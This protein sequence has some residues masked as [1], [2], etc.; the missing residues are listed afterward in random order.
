MNHLRAPI[1]RITVIGNRA[2]VALGPL[3]AEVTTA[4][5]ERLALREGDAV[6]ASFKATATRC[7]RSRVACGPVQRLDLAPAASADHAR[8]ARAAATRAGVVVARAPRLPIDDGWWRA[9]LEEAQARRPAVPSP[10]HAPAVV[11][12]RYEVAP[13]PRSTRGATRA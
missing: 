3:V 9:G 12:S 11:P 7:C 2:R 8:A 1:A 13:S 10:A 6:V 5:L 4:S